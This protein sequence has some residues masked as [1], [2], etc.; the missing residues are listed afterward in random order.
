M[1][2]IGATFERSL[3]SAKQYNLAHEVHKYVIVVALECKLPL[4]LQRLIS[5]PLDHDT[6]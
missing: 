5:P 6:S 3:Q 4:A 1:L 2:D